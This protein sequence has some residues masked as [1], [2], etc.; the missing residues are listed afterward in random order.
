MRDFQPTVVGSSVG[1]A[2]KRS[3]RLVS[4][5]FSRTMK[6]QLVL[7]EI[8]EHMGRRIV[9]ANNFIEGQHRAEIE[10]KLLPKLGG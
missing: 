4:G 3:S 2:F 6:N 5:K 8:V 1:L 9:A 10:V 7:K